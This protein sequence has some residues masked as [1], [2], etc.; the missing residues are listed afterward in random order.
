M[1]PR[2]T[3]ERVRELTDAEA[4]IAR[5]VAY[6]D[7]TRSVGIMVDPRDLRVVHDALARVTRERDAAVAARDALVTA[8]RAEREAKDCVGVEHNA[9]VDANDYA[10][11]RGFGWDTRLRLVS[12]RHRKSVDARIAAT[13]RITALLDGAPADVVRGDVVRAYLAALDAHGSGELADD[14][15]DA[16]RE[17]DARAALDAA[18]LAAKGAP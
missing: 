12:A 14:Y 7:D 3:P 15:S 2:L 11:T 10:E 5:A 16:V 17:V 4:A 8:V 9:L 1:T 18:L 6:C 13:D